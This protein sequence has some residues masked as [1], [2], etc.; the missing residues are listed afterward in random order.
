MY[1]IPCVLD[2]RDEWLFTRGDWENSIKT[3]FAKKF[4]HILEGYVLKNCFKYVAA[5]QSYID[6]IMNK[7][8]AISAY[9]G[10]VVTNGYDDDDFEK[11]TNIPIVKDKKLSLRI[12]GLSGKLHHSEILLPLSTCFMKSTIINMNS[13]IYVLIY[14]GVLL[15]RKKKYIDQC[16]KNK[17]ISVYGYI[18]HEKILNETCN[19][20][21]LLLTL[22]DL[23]GAE[24]IITGKIFE[25]MA[26]G[27]IFCWRSAGR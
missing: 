27:K 18:D 7:Y 5:N 19:S 24:K 13:L 12:Q 14:S 15:K 23:P 20:D 4:D 11:I 6:S 9:K 21:V 8:T 25:Y 16:D 1:G 22:S 17:I 2:Y 10:A 26:T 3:S